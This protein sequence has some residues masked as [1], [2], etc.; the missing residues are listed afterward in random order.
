MG[1]FLKNLISNAANSVN[2]GI[3]KRIDDGSFNR[4][5]ENVGEGVNSL[6]A[7]MVSLV[8]MAENAFGK[9]KDKAVDMKTQYEERV[10][11]RQAEREQMEREAAEERAAR[12]AA[13]EQG[14][15]ESQADSDDEYETAVKATDEY[16]ARLA[17]VYELDDDDF[18][19]LC[20][21]RL[22][23]QAA[24]FFA[25]CDGDYTIRERECINDFKQML[26]TELYSIDSEVLDLTFDKIDQPYTINDI[27][28]MT[29]RLVDDMDEDNRR[30][31]LESIDY[32]AN[33]IVEAD[34]RDDETTALFYD[35]WRREFGL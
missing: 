9:L 1:T 25:N 32:L 16:M 3:R 15:A 8:G 20:M 10:E 14:R 29:H 2:E 35:D 7:G 27:I 30:N 11:S 31:T 19:L 6:A 28:Q 17:E 23:T 26:L 18:T 34:V 13:M 12:L 33:K 5:A 4:M 24:L 21:A 22:T